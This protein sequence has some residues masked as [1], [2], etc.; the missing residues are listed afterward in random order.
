MGAGKVRFVPL[1]NAPLVSLPLPS[2]PFVAC[3]P[4]R[5]PKSVAIT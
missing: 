1:G 3:V 4:S 2:R 5:L